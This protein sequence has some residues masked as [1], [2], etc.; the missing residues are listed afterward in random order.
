MSALISSPHLHSGDS[1]RSTMITVILALAPASFVSVYLFGW[2]GVLVIGTSIGGCMG[3]EWISL[4]MMG[5]ST[6]AVGDGSAALTGLFLALTL[7]PTTSWW[8]VLIGCFMAIM[9]AKQVY[10]GL[11]F[12]L[13]N[14]A[15]AARVILQPASHRFEGVVNGLPKIPVRYIQLQMLNH[16]GRSYLLKRTVQA[17]LPPDH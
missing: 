4:R 16:P 9:L 6:A 13:F 14:P 5:R 2:L 12:N 7:P 11:G 17:G 10:G 1:V 8:M 3:L 15:L